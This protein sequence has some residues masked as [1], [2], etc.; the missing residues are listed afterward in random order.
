MKTFVRFALYGLLV[1]QGTAAE[2]GL[3]RLDGWF[4]F[5]R[6]DHLTTSDPGW[7]GAPGDS[8]PPNYFYRRLEGLAFHP[9]LPAPL[10][11][12]GLYTW[13]SPGRGDYHLSGQPSM[14][15]GPGDTRPPDYTFARKE[16]YAFD[17]PVAGTIPLSGW[18][19]PSAGDNY[20]TT[21]PR[22]VGEGGETRSGYSFVRTEGYVFPTEEQGPL[23]ADYFGHGTT[24][25]NGRRAVGTRPLLVI[26]QE[27]SDQRFR[28]NH[29]LDYYRDLIFG[30]SYSLARHFLAVSYFNFRWSQAGLMQVS[31]TNNPSTP[32]DE[33]AWATWNGG[34]AGY[35]G[36]EYNKWVL[37]QAARAGFNFAL[38]DAN[39]DGQ[40]TTDELGVLIINADPVGFD[41]GQTWVNNPV[42]LNGKAIALNS[43]VI[44]EATGFATIAHELTH[45][46]DV[47]H[48]YGNPSVKYRYSTM[49]GLSWG[50]M[51][52]NT[53]TWTGGIRCV[54]AG[55]N[56]A[57]LLA[58]TPA[59]ALTSTLPSGTAGPPQIINGQL[60]CS[61][62]RAKPTASKSISLSN[63]ARRLTRAK[64]TTR[65]C[66]AP[67]WSSGGF[68][69]IQVP[70]I[71]PTSARLGQ[72][73][74]V[75]WIR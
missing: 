68:G 31:L 10:N 63:F 19:N 21:D 69:R 28:S 36:P 64:T 8:H 6:R 50:T 44:S 35:T 23:D 7:V 12:V 66:P 13:Y 5:D 71:S 60:F 57:S 17:R 61:I 47:E 41:G 37:A 42:T 22:W 27:F 14:A 48:I 51:S 2:T 49:A 1:A 73:P 38:F 54:S 29:T 20:Q 40:L 18:W 9:D 15:G 45:Q 72:G 53:C 30:D 24:L 62:R 4:S 32:L 75:Y 70:T 43:S 39:G 34:N 3:I 26:L 65:A 74:T 58:P 59:H 56:R 16:G 67:A 33:R 25:V 46:L 11:T 52:T 55:S